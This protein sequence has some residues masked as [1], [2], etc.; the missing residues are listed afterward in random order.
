M[1]YQVILSRPAIRDL[2]EIARYLAKDS[3]TVA[4]V[5]GLQLLALAES[6]NLLPRR[7]GAPQIQARGATSRA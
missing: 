2:G 4:E 1:D 3:P 6:L 5:V 7:G